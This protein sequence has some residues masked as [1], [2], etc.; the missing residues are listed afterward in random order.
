L[1][2]DLI[3]T[4]TKR[5]VNG[6]FIFYVIVILLLSILPINSAHS[7]INNTYIIRIRLD[8]LGHISLFLPFLFLGN[9]ALSIKLYPIILFGVFLALFTEGLQFFLPYRAFNINDLIA[10]VLGLL[11]GFLL[12]ISSLSSGLAT[13]LWLDKENTSVITKE[14]E[15]RP[16]ND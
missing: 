13:I 11:L 9:R 12:L 16:R 7:F 1:N 5:N 3:N 6:I 2:S 15:R 14:K 10:N 8:Y 4:S